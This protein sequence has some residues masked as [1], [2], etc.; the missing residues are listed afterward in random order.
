[1]LGKTGCTRKLR[2]LRRG[3]EK[4]KC[5]LCRGNEDV[6]HILLKEQK[7]TNGECNL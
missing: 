3:L 6:K 5:P 4:G 1:M 7:P 2:G